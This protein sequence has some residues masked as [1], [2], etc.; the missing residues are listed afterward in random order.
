M[1]FDTYYNL[2]NSVSPISESEFNSIKILTKEKHFKKGTSLVNPGEVQKSCYFIAEGTMM[3]FHDGGKK[4]LHVQAFAYSPD[5]AAIPESFFHQKPSPHFLQCMSDMRVY[6]LSHSDF[7]T[8]LKTNTSFERL[9]RK[10]TELLLVG[11]LNRQTERSTMTIEE[12]YKTF[13]KRSPHLLQLVPHKYI[14]AYL[15]I[16]PTNFSKLYNSVLI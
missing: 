1:N 2:F 15:D 14:A 10:L 5:I 4:K 13:A 7:E 6:E 3:C 8:L 11:V 16:D 12:R 9:F